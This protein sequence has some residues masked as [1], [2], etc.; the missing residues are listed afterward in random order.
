M[1]PAAIT[2]TSTFEHD[3]RKQHHRRRA[4][5]VLEAATLVA[6]DDEPVDARAPTALSAPRS[7]G[8]TWNTVRPA[9]FSIAV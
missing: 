2:G 9:S 6:L 3:E 8:T 7:D 4:R 5:R 1:P